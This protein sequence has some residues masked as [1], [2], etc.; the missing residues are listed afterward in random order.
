MQY[1][2]KWLIITLDGLDHYKI[3]A[4]W[5]GGYLSGDS[6]RMSSAIEK[7]E[8]FDDHIIFTTH[9]GSEYNCHKLYYGTTAYGGSILPKEAMVLD[10]YEDYTN[11]NK[12]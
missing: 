8:V 6:W 12:K 3:F 10:E 1:P 4:T 11:L 9:T 7:F 2:D 5:H